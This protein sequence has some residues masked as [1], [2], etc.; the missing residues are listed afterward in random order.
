MY[1]DTTVFTCIDCQQALTTGNKLSLFTVSSTFSGQ[2]G[3]VDFAGPFNAGLF[4]NPPVKCVGGAPTGTLILTLNYTMK[5][6][7]IY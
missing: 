2:S 3:M 5:S 4:N 6:L 1:L 7:L